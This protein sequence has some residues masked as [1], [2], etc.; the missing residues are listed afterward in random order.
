[1]IHFQGTMFC[2]TFTSINAEVFDEG[3]LI[4]R[5]IDVMDAPKLHR[6]IVMAD[7][8]EIRR[9]IWF[10]EEDVFRTD[11]DANLPLHSACHHGAPFEIVKYILERN[12]EA[13]RLTGVTE[14]LPLHIVCRPLNGTASRDIVRIILHSYPEAASIPDDE[15]LLPLEIACKHGASIEVLRA[16]LSA[17]VSAVSKYRAHGFQSVDDLWN[18]FSNGDRR[19]AFHDSRKERHRVKTNRRIVEQATSPSDL[20]SE[21][22]H[23][24]ACIELLSWARYYDSVDFQLPFWKKWRVVHALAGS[25]S[26]PEIMKFALKLFPTQIFERDEEGNLPLHIASPNLRRS[27]CRNCCHKQNLLIDV[28][29]KACPETARKRDRAGSLPLHIVLMNRNIKSIGQVDLLLK[30]YPGAICTK[31]PKTKLYPFMLAAMQKKFTGIE[32]S[33]LKEDNHDLSI[34]FELLLKN[35]ELVRIGI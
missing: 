29:V 12:P 32:T 24:W 31:D 16:L 26:H 9:N 5:G 21:L 6:K 3:Q 23:L 10:C 14:S 30:S 15:G 35:P 4:I 1:M 25:D 27:E 33:K 17:N 7:W 34:S 11:F 13:V 19:G 22:G 20:V 8:N 18:R 28:L 2:N